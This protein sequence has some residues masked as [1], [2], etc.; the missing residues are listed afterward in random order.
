M[1]A[2]NPG[3]NNFIKWLFTSISVACLNEGIGFGTE[4]LTKFMQKRQ[5]KSDG[6]AYL[7]R[8]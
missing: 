3:Q 6:F 1:I 2:D 8:I 4:F 5:K 7:S